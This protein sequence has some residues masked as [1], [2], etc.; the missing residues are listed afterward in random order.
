ML[1]IKR[2]RPNPV[3]PP[4]ITQIFGRDGIGNSRSQPRGRLGANVHHPGGF[5]WSCGDGGMRDW[6][7]LD[8]TTSFIPLIVFLEGLKKMGSSPA[9][10]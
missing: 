4:G 2:I 3:A 7:T 10:I 6:V 9:G 8:T 1:D 5:R